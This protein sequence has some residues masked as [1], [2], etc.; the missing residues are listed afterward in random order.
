MF[1]YGR[2]FLRSLGRR[3]LVAAA[4]LVITSVTTIISIFYEEQIKEILSNYNITPSNIFIFLVDRPFLIPALVLTSYFAWAFYEVVTASNWDDVAFSE[5]N[6]NS[7]YEGVGW[8]IR[9]K[10]NKEKDIVCFQADIYQMEERNPNSEYS[11]PPFDFPF[12]LAVSAG[13]ERLIHSGVTIGRGKEGIITLAMQINN[14][15]LITG[16]MVK[17]TMMDNSEA[18]IVVRVS[19]DYDEIPLKPKFISAKLS[20]VNNV[21][22]IGEVRSVKP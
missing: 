4:I 11:L 5:Y 9:V 15:Y 7:P 21:L 10:N 6:P 8:G 22:A 14:H 1:S 12:G 19:G 13:I 20:L 18:Q 2:A 3:F 17:I 16:H